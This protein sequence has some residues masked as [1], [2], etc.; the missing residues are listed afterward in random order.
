M[1]AMSDEEIRQALDNATI[2]TEEQIDVG[3]QE[4]ARLAA[5][6]E[7]LE[8]AEA[9]LRANRLHDRE[10]IRQAMTRLWADLGLL[11]SVGEEGTQ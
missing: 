7:A 8:R 2:E 4:M 1:S 10:T 6:V 11:P 5:E 3:R 9:W